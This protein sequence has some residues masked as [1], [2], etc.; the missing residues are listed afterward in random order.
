MVG[1]FNIHVDDDKDRVTKLFLEML[2]SVDL[3]QHIQGPTHNR[4]HTLD[5][6][7]SR[8]SENKVLQTSVL[9]G[10][11]SDHDAIMGVLEFVRPGPSKKT[12]V[13]RKLREIDIEQFKKDISESLVSDGSKDVSALVDQFNK[14][15]QELLNKHAPQTE[16]KTITLRPRVP[17]FTDDMRKERRK[18][19]D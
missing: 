8:K 1:D 2:D 11:P 16:T 14:V 5:L 13:F 10:L 15:L 7:I 4:D 12:V 19:E 3:K 18:K 6:L 17:W 9:N